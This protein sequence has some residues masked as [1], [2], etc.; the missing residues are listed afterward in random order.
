MRKLRLALPWTATV[1]SVA[2]FSSGCATA[3]RSVEDGLRND[4]AIAQPTAQEERAL[5]DSAVAQTVADEVGPRV[6]V[7][8][9]FDY[10]GGSR[11]V[12]ARFH[13]YDDAYVIVGHLD[14]AGRLRIVFPSDPRDDGFVRGG[15]IYHVP[16][17]FAGFADEYAWRYSEYRY[18]YH[19]ISSRRD[20]YDAG[21]GYVFV[22]ASW[23]PMRLDR[24]ADGDRWQTYNVADV[25]YMDDP[26]EAIEELG[27]LVAGDNREAYSI[28]YAHYTTTNYGMYS[29]SDFD[30]VNGGCFG[31]GS[32]GL[33]GFGFS[34]FLFSPASFYGFG[35]SACPSA[36][37]YRYGGYA[38]GNLYP[39]SQPVF[40][41]PPVIR[42]PIEK[43]VIGTP[44]FRRPQ[45]GGTVALHHPE[46]TGNAPD[47]SSSTIT[48]VNTGSG[49][50]R[51]G[52]FA[53]DAAAPRGQGR[54]AQTDAQIPS[55]SERPTIQDMI[56]RRRVEQ[57]TRGFTPGGTRIRDNGGWTQREPTWTNRGS[58]A[59]RPRDEGTTVR[60]SE[61]ARSVDHG[62]RSSEPRA[63]SSPRSEPRGESSR[64]ARSE[65]RSEPTR[66]APARAEPASR[67]S[68]PPPAS[69]PSTRKPG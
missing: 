33:L 62:T 25:S 47:G 43:P 8:A 41:G 55:T 12:D 49:Y 58:A 10:A 65:P 1:L 22:I 66:S 36:Y 19:S 24:L 21:L 56:G 53:E 11:R 54:S 37:G 51:P 14:A 20:S 18:R 69:S 42:P 23:R 30:R 48:R 7:T 2:V 39:G 59:S 26:R 67:P 46:T 9:D 64:P 60:R 35:S 57:A 6:S 31:Y 68:S 3:T 32:L 27:A 29:F 16:S 38:Y 34:P 61:G 5:R 45:V 44:V 13:L 28:Q 50:H 40:Q 17:F 63:T 52:L 4:P 15:K